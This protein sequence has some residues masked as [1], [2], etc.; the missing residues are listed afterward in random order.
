LLIFFLDNASKDWFLEYLKECDRKRTLPLA[1]VAMQGIRK[2]QYH[3]FNYQMSEGIASALS[4]SLSSTI[5]EEKLSSMALVD[6]GLTDNKISEILD[7]AFGGRHPL[8]SIS[9]SNNEFGPLSVQK[10]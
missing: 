10:L 2:G 5:T 4:K 1:E 6:N 3:L 9:I 7:C 8:K